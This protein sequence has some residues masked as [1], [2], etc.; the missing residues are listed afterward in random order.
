MNCK[1]VQRQLVS[2]INGELEEK[3]EEEFVKHIR[4]CPEC[5]EELEVYSTVFAVIRQ[6]DGA[7]EEIDYRTLVEDYLETSEEDAK[8]EHFLSTYVFLLR[9]VV[10]VLLFY[11]IV[12]CFLG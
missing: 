12:R 8:D 10:T 11:M 9:I 1:Q 2:Y 4:H 3:E 7:E 5:Y 6:L